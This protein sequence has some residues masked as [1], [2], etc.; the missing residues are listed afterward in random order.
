[1]KPVLLD[2]GVIVALLDL[3]EKFQQSCAAILHDL[4]TPWL[5]AKL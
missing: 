4:R 1:L 3:S 5:P 2:T